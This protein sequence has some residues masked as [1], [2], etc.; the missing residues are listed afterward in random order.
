MKIFFLFIS[1][2]FGGSVFCQ[3]ANDTV[4]VFSFSPDL[5][6]SLIFEEVN[7]VRSENDLTQ[8]FYSDSLNQQANDHVLQMVKLR[9]TFYSDSTSKVEECNLKIFF[10]NSNPTV[11][12]RELAGRMVKQWLNSP[13]AARLILGE[14]F[15]YGGC[16]V[17]YEE[18]KNISEIYIYT[19]F[20][21]SP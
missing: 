11:T 21:I 4:D 9:K 14:F 17:T 3:T 15:L 19:C 12:Y 10:R 5:L 16:G 7:R 2:L 6:D 13:A 8:L 18:W 1:I 20:R